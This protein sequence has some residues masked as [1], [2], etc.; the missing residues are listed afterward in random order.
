MKIFNHITTNEF[1]ELKKKEVNGSRQYLIED[2]KVYPSITTVLGKDPSKLEGL[3]KWRKRIG[4]EKASKISTQSSRRG[5]RVH[6]IVEAYLMNDLNGQYNHNPLAMG[7]FTIIQPVL[8]ERLDNIHAQEVTLWSDHLGVAGQV[9][10]V[11][12]FDNKI[13]IV[14]FKTSS[15][16]KKPEWIHDY[17]KQAA[18]YAVMWEE[19]TAIP[20]TQLV[21]VVTVSDEPKPQI[22]VEH[23]DN[24]TESLIESIDYY[25]KEYMN[26]L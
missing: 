25:K 14:D 15:K 26:G 17:Y 16:L 7:M 1:R 9:D 4:T 24:W 22:F 18:G 13:S 19:R 2:N 6:N 21:I 23:R 10:C 12:E 11:A 20:I 3:K 8:D 5:T